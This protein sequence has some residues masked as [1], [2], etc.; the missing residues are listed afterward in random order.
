MVSSPRAAFWRRPGCR[1][2]RKFAMRRSMRGRRSGS[3]QSSG[4]AH[5]SEMASKKA[6][7]VLAGTRTGGATPSGTAT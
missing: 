6:R 2:S 4:A 5:A 3:F 1:S 7:T